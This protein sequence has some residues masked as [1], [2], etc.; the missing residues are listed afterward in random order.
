MPV[1]SLR[2]VGS[3]PPTLTPLCHWLLPSR[4]LLLLLLRCLGAAFQ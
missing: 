2:A 1:A 4:L 3:Q